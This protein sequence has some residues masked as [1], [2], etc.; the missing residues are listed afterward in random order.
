MTDFES[1]NITYQS[2]EIS[3]NNDIY[4]ANDL[5]LKH[6]RRKILRNKIQKVSLIFFTFFF[7]SFF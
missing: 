4:E 5:K 3:T 7:F 6:Q 1:G 2:F